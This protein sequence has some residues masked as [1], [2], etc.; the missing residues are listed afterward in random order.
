MGG[1]DEV[2]KAG[3]PAGEFAPAGRDWSLCPA[4]AFNGLAETPPQEGGQSAL[5]RPPALTCVSS[6]STLVETLHGPA[7]L[8]H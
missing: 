6:R 2:P 7:E 3:S 4:Q 8:T 1:A 5:S